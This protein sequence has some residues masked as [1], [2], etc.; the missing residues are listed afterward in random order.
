MA[1]AAKDVGMNVTAQETVAPGTTDFAPLLEKRKGGALDLL[2][3]ALGGSTAGF[4]RAYEAS[5]WKVPISGRIDFT[6]ALGAVTPEFRA[7]GGLSG[8]SGITVFTPALSNPGVRDFVTA[9]QAHYGLVP[10]QRSFFVYEATY[11]VVDA[12]RRAGSDKP[13][14]VEDALKTTTM[15]SLL[16]GTYKMDEHNHPHTPLFILRLQDG[17]PAVIA[18]E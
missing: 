12:I 5:G 18:A 3:T 9:S 1:Q 11:L 2:L 7:A 6:A 4:F 13:A 15:A 14:A 16:G 17:K 8:L 10:T